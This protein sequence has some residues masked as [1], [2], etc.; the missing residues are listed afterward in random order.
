MELTEKSQLFL[1][2]MVHW[3]KEEIHLW[4]DPELPHWVA[5]D[6]RGAQIMRW[7]REGLV[8]GEMIRRYAVTF[9]VDVPKAWLHVHDF[10]GAL[11]RSG[12][13][14]MQPVE[15]I[16]YQGRAAYARPAGLKELWFHTNNICNLACTHCLVNSA[17]WVQDW[18][19]PTDR[20]LQLV[21]EAAALGVE[22]FYFTG[23][24]PFMR[25]DIIELIRFITEA[26][27][28]ELIVLTNATLF[29]GER[30]EAL[31]TLDRQRVRFQVSID[32]ASP[33]TNDQIRGKGSFQAAV[34]GL[35]FLA[36]MGFQTSITTAVT[37]TNLQDLLGITRLASELGVATQHLMWL[38]RRGR[39]VS[40]EKAGHGSNGNGSNAAGSGF[41]S[42][43]QLIDL[44]RQ[45][46][47]LAGELGVA[48]DNIESIKRRVNG[49]PGVKYD[50]GNACWDSICIY[51]D[52]MVYPSA[53]LVN[54]RHLALGSIKEG[55]GLQELWERSPVAEAFRQATVARK[56]DLRGDPFRYLTGGGDL[57]HS[58]WFNAAGGRSGF[59]SSSESHLNGE[60]SAAAISPERITALLTG[61]DPYYPLYT[62]MIQDAMWELSRTAQ[63]AVN[64]RS[65]YDVPRLL[66]VMGDGAIHCATDDLRQPLKAVGSGEASSSRSHDLAVSGEINVRTL[67]SNCV[68]A[69]D[70][71]RPRKLVREFYG[72]AAEIPQPELCCPTKFDPSL[73]GH[74]PKEVVDR[75]YGCGSP[76]TLGDLKLGETMIDLGSGAGIDCFIAAKFVGPTGKVIGVDMTDEMLKVANENRPRVA[77]NLGY[78]V[79]EF[80]KGYL[81]DVPVES[82][83][84]DLVTSNCV[85]NLSP[86]K[87]RVFAEIWR[88]LKDHGRVVIADIVSERPVPANLKVNPQLWGE[89]IV[90]ALT[91]EEFLARLEE[92]GFYGLSILK[93]AYWKAVE[94]FDFYSVIVEG[95]KFE[96]SAAAPGEASSS[97]SQTA[98]CRF[99]GQRAVYLG[100][101][102]SAMDEEGHL[103]PRN[104]AVEVCTD[105]AAK[106]SRPPY[107]GS[108][109]VLEPD[110]VSS[111]R[112][113][114]TGRRSNDGVTECS[115]GC[116]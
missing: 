111:L 108:F 57:E 37:A 88:V 107:A 30:A 70:V 90:G 41:P 50:L 9:G 60:S 56:E 24:E 68:L 114:P 77:H 43:D 14:Q 18:G 85:V 95:Y 109:T 98:G 6:P 19:M 83:S 54:I 69:F 82:K 52:G 72:Q 81:E 39:I 58:F 46:K 74:I 21:D 73:V 91:E 53:A 7:I 92:A 71:D 36:S 65:G 101:M 51:S 13:A 34:E 44:V 17:P 96:K 66:H 61:P 23:G 86:D 5:T 38:H 45:V 102:K 106:L 42:A 35:R 33:E 16:A 28:R 80:R 49:R 59:A 62:A 20:F 87:P 116:C 48:V 89:C 55:A 97:R 12:F 1:P 2:E 79:V 67:H 78:D 31:K 100:P 40:P 32:G 26:K 104:V 110:T 84:V 99:I 47:E 105:T 103:F 115:P 10:V 27:R 63:A 4:L 75:F 29:R 15:H 11:L 64:R 22:R 93:K 76:V 112:G 94:G 25:K 113:G 3:R 8:F